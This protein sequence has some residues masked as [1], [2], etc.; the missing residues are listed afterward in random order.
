MQKVTFIRQM[1]RLANL[2]GQE[3]T[4]PRVDAYWSVLGAMDEQVFVAACQRCM[5]EETFFPVP[6]VIIKHARLLT[7][8]GSAAQEAWDAVRGSIARWQPG[9]PWQFEIGPPTR[10]GLDAIGG[11][12]RLVELTDH[13]AP[14]VRKEFIAAYEAWQQTDTDQ[15]LLLGAPSP[16]PLLV[17]PEVLDDDRN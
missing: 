8:D 6:A 3:L 1:E 16:R 5:T 17:S 12:K 2:Y 10:A 11:A 4:K 7:I 14:Y 13:D 15:R 9:T